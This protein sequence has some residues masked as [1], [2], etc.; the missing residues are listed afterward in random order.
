M[1]S[2]VLYGVMELYSSRA[3][4]NVCRQ[5]INIM[6]LLPGNPPPSHGMINVFRKHLLQGW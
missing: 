5:N 2:I 3:L 1:V 6:W 4:A